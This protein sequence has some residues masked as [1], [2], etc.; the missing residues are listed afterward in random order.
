MARRRRFPADRVRDRI[1]FLRVIL[2]EPCHGLTGQG[3]G[4]LG[5]DDGNVEPLVETVCDDAQK[6]AGLA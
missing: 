3:L 6:A 1:K 5:K 4:A 2:L